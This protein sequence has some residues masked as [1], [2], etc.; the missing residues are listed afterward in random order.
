LSRSVFL[1]ATTLVAILGAPA[2]RAEDGRAAAIVERF[3][4]ANAWRGHVMVAAHRGGWMEGGEIRLAENSLSSLQRAIDLG[5]EIVEADI[6]RTRDGEFVILHDETLDRTTTCKGEVAQQTLAQLGDC[7]LV[8]EGTGAVTGEGVPTLQAFLEAAK[9]R[10]MVNLDSKLGVES[11]A[12]M[13]AMARE[14]GMSEQIVAKAYVDKPEQFEAAR[15]VLSAMGPQGQ[16][17]PQL[18]DAVSRDL[19]PMRRAAVDLRPQAMELRNTHEAG[20]PPTPDGG[21][22]FAMPARALAV[23]HDVHL[24]INTL[25]DDKTNGLRSGGRGDEMAIRAGLPGEVYGFWAEHGATL[26]QTDEPK[27][28]IEWLAAHGYRIPY[29][30]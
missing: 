5:V 11:L 8:V 20:L 18:S 25:Y 17:M 28:A 16:F 4:D 26:I 15:A 30:E 23:R 7:R 29:R 14:L 27:A 3:R 6:Q 19:E 12:A 9:G 10:I 22:F 24:W 21:L 1:L 2:S 13:T